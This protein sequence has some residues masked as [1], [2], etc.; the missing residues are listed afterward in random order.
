[1]AINWILP[2]IDLDLCDGCGLCGAACPAG[3]VEVGRT[4]AHIARPGDCTYCTLCE[5]ACPR[6]AI[7]CTFEIVWGG[8]DPH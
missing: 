2:I 6:G 5:S 4:G 7:A 8:G 3:A 1:M